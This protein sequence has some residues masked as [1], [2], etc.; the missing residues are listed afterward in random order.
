MMNEIR[1]SIIGK[2]ADGGRQ[3]LH[4]DH[5]PQEDAVDGS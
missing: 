1:N 4:P 3:R 5:V 2:N